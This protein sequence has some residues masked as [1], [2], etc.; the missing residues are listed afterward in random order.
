MKIVYSIPCS[1]ETCGSCSK[2]KVTIAENAYDLPTGFCTLF[3]DQLTL[4]SKQK[5]VTCFYRSRKCKLAERSYL[6]LKTG[7]K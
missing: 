2:L 1:K 3:D 5:F 6:L 4:M 7:E